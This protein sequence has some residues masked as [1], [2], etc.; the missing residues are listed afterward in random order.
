MTGA[1][2][3]GGAWSRPLRKL[4]DSLGD[5]FLARIALCTGARTYTA[6]ERIHVMPVDRLWA[7]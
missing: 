1:A 4:R 3:P 5:R 7:A 2:H 6:A